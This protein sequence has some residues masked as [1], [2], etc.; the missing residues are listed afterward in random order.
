M[1][2][3]YYDKLLA[4]TGHTSAPMKSKVGLSLL[5]KLGWKEGKGL[6]KKE[7]GRTNCV[8]LKRR[9]ENMGLGFE[10]AAPAEDPK[11]GNE[12][13]ET[14]YNDA[15]KNLE[16]VVSKET[17]DDQSEESV[18]EAAARKVPRKKPI[19]KIKEQTQ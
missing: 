17:T 15:A 12:F 9:A 8:Q 14:I 7:D 18:G 6:G 16:V 3:K 4:G 5:K 13:W 11:W 10:E 1:S 2:R 19:R